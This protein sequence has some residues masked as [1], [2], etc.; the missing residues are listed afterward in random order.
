MSLP[1]T[2]A[3]VAVLAAAELDTLRRS[4]DLQHA[5]AIKARGTQEALQRAS[6]IDAL[7]QQLI[8]MACLYSVLHGLGDTAA[9]DAF[10]DDWRRTGAYLRE[11]MTT[12]RMC[13]VPG[14]N[15]ATRTFDT[16]A[17]PVAA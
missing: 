5:L 15:P 3:A 12:A 1:T 14:W 4:A 2:T 11:A 17:A 8:G 9:A 16:V 13:A 10:Q 6:C 7:H